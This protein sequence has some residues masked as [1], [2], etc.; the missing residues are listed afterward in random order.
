MVSTVSERAVGGHQQ[1]DWY[2]QHQVIDQA[3]D[4]YRSLRPYLCDCGSESSS[5]S[6][7]SG[8]ELQNLFLWTICCDLE[9]DLSSK[10]FRQANH[11]ESLDL[12]SWASSLW[13]LSLL[14]RYCHRQQ[15]ASWVDRV[16]D[17]KF[18]WDYR[19]FVA[20]TDQN[21]GF[22]ERETRWCTSCQVIQDWP[23][24][25]K[26][27]V[28]HEATVVTSALHLWRH[29]WEW[30]DRLRLQPWQPHFTSHMCLPDVGWIVRFYDYGWQNVT[31]LLARWRNP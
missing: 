3:L 20:Q 26:A 8:Y 6:R 25:P 27:M 14:W 21:L 15:L 29:S 16:S 18:E 31:F 11:Y 19:L 28:F 30:S 5:W 22:Q 12:K 24:L 9:L 2:Y 4:Y 1:E 23:V 10:I 7:F 13:H 17:P